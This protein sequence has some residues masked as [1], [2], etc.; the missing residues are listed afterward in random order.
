MERTE[1]VP[2]LKSWCRGEGLDETHAL[3]TI[4]P[5]EVEISEV[6]ETLQTFK[7]L[8]WV[9][10]HGRNFS[11]RLNRQIV[12]CESRETVKEESVPP[13][14]VPIDDG[15]AWAIIL[16]EVQAAAEEFNT[17]LKGLL[18]AEG[19]TVE[20]LK[21]LLPSA[22]PPT[23]STESILHAIGDLLDKATKPA[24]GGSYCRLRM[25]SGALPTPPGEEPFDH[26]LE[27]AWLMVE[28]TEFSEREKRRRLMGSLNGPA[29]EIV[30]VARHTNPDSSRKECLEALES[31]FGS[32]E[33]GDDLYFTFQLM[34]Q[35]KGEKLSDFLRRLERS[36]AKVI[37][38]SG[39]PASYMDRAR[40][41][42]LLT[43]AT[44]PDLMPI[45]LRLRER[46]AALPNFLQLL[47][48]NCA[49]EEYEAYRKKLSALVYQVHANPEVYIRQAEIQS[50]KA[51]IRELK[52]TVASVV[53]KSAHVKDDYIEDTPRSAPPG[54]E[55]R[56]DI[57]LAA[58]KKQLK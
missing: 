20:D 31:A 24:D 4:V 53:T 45:Q 2:E 9:R 40:L 38:R 47:T 11:A 54:P 48:E 16:G 32:A 10:I 27:Q 18:Q 22:P 3:M 25:F 58:L 6:E 30:K 43:G 49:E 33:S 39:L 26:W 29:L 50:L 12:L 52:S 55:N 21:S 28:E 37:Q 44:A 15:E 14:V 13:E 57:E 35:Q 17:K 23:S 41:E 19:K 5:E 36:L 1:L 34:Q 7:C 51:E 56:Q 8:G 46:K 42:Q